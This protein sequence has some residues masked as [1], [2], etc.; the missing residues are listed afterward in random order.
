MFAAIGLNLIST[1]LIGLNTAVLL[2]CAGMMMTIFTL[3][4]AFSAAFR[5]MG[6]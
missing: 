4:A 1:A 2:V 6:R 3:L 5:E